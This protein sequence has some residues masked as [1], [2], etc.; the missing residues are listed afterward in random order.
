MMRNFKSIC[1][2]LVLVG[3]T[4]QAHAYVLPAEYIMRML[5]DKISRLK[6]EDVSIKLEAQQ[7]SE[8]VAERFYLKRAERSRLLSGADE[9]LIYVEREG[10]ITDMASGTLQRSR[11]NRT[12]VLTALLFPAGKNLDERAV[13]MLSVLSTAGIDT[14]VVALG[15]SGNRPV[16]IVGAKSFEPLK[17]QV[18][19]D[20]KSFVPVRSILYTAAEAAGDK[21]EKRYLDHQK[22]A[23]G[24]WFPSIIETWKNNILVKEQVV[25]EAKKNQKLPE[26]MFRAP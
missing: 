12:D 1:T 14:S 20:K 3:L 7:G 9:A 6:I 17:S 4:T 26:S 25:V 10:Q 8:T 11:A 13:R 2:V 22:S 24:R 19:F 21:V 23:A 15:R 5:A 18:W 16:Y